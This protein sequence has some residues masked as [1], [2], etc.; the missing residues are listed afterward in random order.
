MPT[1]GPAVD[2]V[3]VQELIWE[4]L[5]EHALLDRRR[6]RRKSDLTSHLGQ[7]GIRARHHGQDQH[8]V[9]TADKA[10]ERNERPRHAPQGDPA[11]LHRNELGVSGPSGRGDQDGK[12]GSY[13]KRQRQ[14]VR[15]PEQEE[16]QTGR[17]VHVSRDE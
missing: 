3:D 10:G 12:Q 1:A 7:L 5:C 11:R 16:P 14:D 15:H 4:T 6:G 17:D 9:D 8:Q 2:L 13:G